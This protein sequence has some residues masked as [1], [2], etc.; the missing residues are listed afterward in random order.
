MTQE[1]KPGRPNSIP[2]VPG[3][4]PT[5][6]R[7]GCPG[8]SPRPGATK[9]CHKA[10]WSHLL[11]APSPRGLLGFLPGEAAQAPSRD[12][13]LPSK[14]AAPGPPP[15]PGRARSRRCQPQPACQRTGA[16]GHWG[17]RTLRASESGRRAAPG[18]VKVASASSPIRRRCRA[19]EQRGMRGSPS[20]PSVRS[21]SFFSSGERA[22]AARSRKSRGQRP[23]EA[24]AISAKAPDP[25]W[26][27]GGGTRK[28][29]RGRRE[30][31]WARAAG[32]A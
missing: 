26:P 11:S 14:R 18:R 10:L 22:A 25:D 32:G 21:A 27:P 4:W 6:P 29:P 20:A 19:E 5:F 2:R 28:N 16:W 31:S 1:W 9:P 15:T 3:H 30:G 17:S 7:H 24:P 12:S 13:P 8:R 23:S